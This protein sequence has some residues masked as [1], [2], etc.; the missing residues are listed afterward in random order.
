MTQNQ[1]NELKTKAF[2]SDEENKYS[3]KYNHNQV[4]WNTSLNPD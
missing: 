4:A 1:K 3:F 2:C